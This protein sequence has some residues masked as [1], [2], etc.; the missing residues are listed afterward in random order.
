MAHPLSDIQRIVLDAISVHGAVGT[1]KLAE[2]TGLKEHTIRYGLV[3]CLREGLTTEYRQV[4]YG[5][6]GLQTFNLFFSLGSG[7]PEAVLSLL[8]SDPRVVWLSENVEQ[9]RYE[10][11]VVV[12]NP[13]ELI[14]LC[15]LMTQETGVSFVD[16]AWAIELSFLIFGDRFLSRKVSGNPIP[17]DLTLPPT[18]VDSLDLRILDCCESHGASVPTIARNLG[19]PASSIDYRLKRLIS[20][21]VVTPSLYSAEPAK[22]GLTECQYIASFREIHRDLDQRMVEFCTRNVNVMKLVRTFG[23]WNYKVI[24]RAENIDQLVSVREEFESVFGAALASVRFLIR[25]R[26]L[27]RTVLL[28]VHPE[29]SQFRDK[30]AERAPG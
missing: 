22:V 27:R 24:A 3:G 10:A 8:S 20:R 26:V 2:L 13:A 28:S 5:T 14:R 15:T 18:T 19:Q 12:K 11:T 30:L 7:N 23:T 17:V 9:P 21:F 29:L 1:K 4:N 25:R 16:L 6:L